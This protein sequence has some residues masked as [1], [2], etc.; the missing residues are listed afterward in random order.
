MAELEYR[1]NEAFQAAKA[2][3]DAEKLDRETHRREFIKKLI[4]DRRRAQQ[5]ERES[6]QEAERKRMEE[7]KAAH[8]AQRRQDTERL[9]EM[10]KERLRR[11]AEERARAREEAE[12]EQSLKEARLEAIR[13][14]VR[15]I[16]PDD[17]SRLLSSTAV[18][19]NQHRLEQSHPLPE[20]MEGI[21][22][23]RFYLTIDNPLNTFTDKQLQSDRRTRLSAALF[24]AGLLDSDYARDLLAQVPLERPVRLEM[25][26]SLEAEER[27]MKGTSKYAPR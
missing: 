2:R 8:E 20:E 19:Q 5:A 21:E 7:L 3:L 15:P 1:A 6:L 4:L 12:R 25:M 24:D 17:P 26:T 14:K 10:E 22:L 16:V 23:R 13:M 11:L 9:A 27:R 18:S